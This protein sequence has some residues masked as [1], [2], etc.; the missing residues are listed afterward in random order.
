MTLTRTVIDSDFPVKAQSSSS[1]KSQPQFEQL[2]LKQIATLHENTRARVCESHD[3]TDEASA[4]LVRVELP[5]DLRMRSGVPLGDPGGEYVMRSGV[6]LYYADA[7]KQKR[8]CYRITSVKRNNFC[9]DVSTNKN[10]RKRN[11]RR[12]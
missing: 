10:K 5:R 7:K 11:R 4:P 3:E 1:R 12:K 8:S 6:P 9:A 2:L